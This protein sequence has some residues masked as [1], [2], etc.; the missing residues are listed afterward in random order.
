MN[1]YSRLIIHS[2]LVFKYL[3]K[4]A[5]VVLM[6]II[7]RLHR[8]YHPHCEVPKSNNII[9][10]D[11]GWNQYTMIIYIPNRRNRRKLFKTSNYLSI[12]VDFPKWPSNRKGF[13]L[14]F[15]FADSYSLLKS[16]RWTKLNSGVVGLMDVVFPFPF[17]LNW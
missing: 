16:N 4:I 10:E 9:C 11:K 12:F 3:C 8:K 1:K 5:S 14:F 17:A 7:V 2:T 15:A 6:I 13:S